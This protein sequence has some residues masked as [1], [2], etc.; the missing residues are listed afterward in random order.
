MRRLIEFF[1]IKYIDLKIWL[2]DK[3]NGT[4]FDMFKF[5]L[6]WMLIMILAS[7]LIGKIL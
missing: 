2:Q 7:M 6:F 1:I 3:K 5:G 4:T